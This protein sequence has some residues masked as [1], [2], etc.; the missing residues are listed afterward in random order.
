MKE[1]CGCCTGHANSLEAQEPPAVDGC[2]FVPVATVIQGGADGGRR[3]LSRSRR[4]GCLDMYDMIWLS[5]GCASPSVSAFAMN[6]NG[7]VSAERH[8]PLP[9]I[10]ATLS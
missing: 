7:I 8:G 2:G 10:A 1:G 9:G 4:I 3:D 6:T 5:V